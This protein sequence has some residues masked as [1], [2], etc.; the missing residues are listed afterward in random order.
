MTR[1]FLLLLAALAITG[2]A[3]TQTGGGGFDEMPNATEEE[4]EQVAFE[5]TGDVWVYYY[6]KRAQL[7]SAREEGTYVEQPEQLYVLVNKSHSLY[8]G[9]PDHRMK[10]EERFVW[11]A[12]MYNFLVVL[13]DQMGFFDKGNAVN[14]LDE[15]P[16]KR[17]DREGRTTRMIAVRQIKNGKVNTSYFARHADEHN[18]NK[19]RARVFNNCQDLFRQALS[20]ALPRGDVEYGAGDPDSIGRGRPD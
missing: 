6:V 5:R 13:R 15:D 19:D 7:P 16:I 20:T 14:I 3:T 9:L 4:R 11:N 8:Q 17:A 10:K 18:T 1:P 2:C 12:D